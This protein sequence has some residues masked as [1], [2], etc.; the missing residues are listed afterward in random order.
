MLRIGKRV[1]G[2]E[3]ERSI[4]ILIRSLSQHLNFHESSWIAHSTQNQNDR[5]IRPGVL[6]F[7]SVKYVT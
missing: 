3:R 2:W 1:W 7:L 6:F 4:N 5:I